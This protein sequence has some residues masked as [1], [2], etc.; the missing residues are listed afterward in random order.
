[1]LTE[2][3]FDGAEEIE[4]YLSERL[5]IALRYN[6]TLKH[7]SFKNIEICN[8]QFHCLQTILNLNSTSIELTI[9]KIEIY[10]MNNELLGHL[11]D[12]VEHNR[13][14]LSV[15]PPQKSETQLDLS[16]MC[17]ADREI[18]SLA[19]VLQLAESLEQNN[20]LIGLDL[21]QNTMTYLGRSY[22]KN[23]LVE[24]QT[25]IQL[26][27][28]ASYGPI[29]ELQQPLALSKIIDQMQACTRLDL[30]D[31][32]INSNDIQLFATVLKTNSTLTEL[33]LQNSNINTERTKYLAEAL[34]ENKTLVTVNLIANTIEEMLDF[35][36][37]LI[38]HQC[39]WTLKKLLV[40]NPGNLVKLVKSLTDQI[41]QMLVTTDAKL[42]L[43][44]KLPRS[45]MLG[46]IEML[47]L[48]EKLKSNTTFT[49]LDFHANEISNYGAQYLGDVLMLWI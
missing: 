33:D 32:R 6:T 31:G 26:K 43:S 42:D 13:I 5:I 48:A 24:S 10:G 15:V 7:I 41:N 47:I 19:D 21:S 29:R 9:H 11:I 18:E 16:Q 3:N 34:K 8:T 12:F 14:H 17:L 20:T 38:V 45:S 2:L 40:N 44:N 35:I 25:L 49:E 39:I 1:T 27:Y 46:E 30:S 37:N 22:F 36:L 28:D 23:A 4:N